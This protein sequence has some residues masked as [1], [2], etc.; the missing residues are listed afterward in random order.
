MAGRVKDGK[1]HHGMALL[2]EK[3][4]GF[5][6]GRERNRK[7]IGQVRSGKVFWF[8]PANNREHHVRCYYYAWSCLMAFVFPRLTL[9]LFKTLFF[10]FRGQCS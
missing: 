2:R 8:F 1:G 7:G 6:F 9:C 5:C 10:L 4:I 3:R